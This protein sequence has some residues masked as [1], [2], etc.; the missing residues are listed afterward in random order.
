LEQY[1]KNT[2]D[3]LANQDFM[4]HAPQKV[5]ADIQKKLAEA[6]QKLQ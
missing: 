6:K 5:I 3:K 1:I 4:A 2:Q